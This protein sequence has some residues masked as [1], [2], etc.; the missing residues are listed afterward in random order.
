VLAERIRGA[1]LARLP[2]AGH[3]FFWEQPEAFVRIVTEFLG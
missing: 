2:G 1:R 3:L